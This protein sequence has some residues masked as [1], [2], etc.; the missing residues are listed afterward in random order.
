MTI[1]IGKNTNTMHI[2]SN[3]RRLK[4]VEESN[5]GGMRLK[6]FQFDHGREKHIEDKNNRKWE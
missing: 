3:T 4:L 5:N 2:G 1:T 6:V